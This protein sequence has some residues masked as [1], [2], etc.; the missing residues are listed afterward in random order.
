MAGFSN[1]LANAIINTTLRGA[2]FPAIGTCYF[3]LFKSDPGDGFSSAAEL[4]NDGLAPWYVRKPI[5][6]FEVPTAG[7]TFN[8]TRVEFPAVTSAP[9]TVTHV[10]IV[11]GSGPSDSG[12]KLLYSEALPAFRTLLINDVFVIDSAALSGDFTLTLL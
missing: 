10:G 11:E 5:G 2:T 3:A 8:T 6:N 1:H 12:A 7:T 4:N 9:A